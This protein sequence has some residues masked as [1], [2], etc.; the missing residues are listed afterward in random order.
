MDR[1]DF[2]KMV[3]VASGTSI[4]AGCNLDRETEKLIPYLVPPEDG[5]VPGD[6]VYKPTS[7][8][9][10]PAACGMRVTIKDERPAK[11]EG[12]ESHPVGNGALCVRG[13]ASLE[14]L[15]H[16]DRIKQPLMRDGA[17]NFAPAT[18]QQAYAAVVK[19]M[20]VGKENVFLSG[21]TTGT[22]SRLVDEFC[23]R[24]GVTRLPEF[25][26]Y[27]YA[28][29]REA[30]SRLF[31]R[32]VVPA[33]RFEKAD[34]LL[35][36]GADLLDTYGNPVDNTQKISQAR[37]GGGE[38]AHFKW[39]HAE[40]HAT[41]TG[42]RADHRLSVRPGSEATLLAYLLHELRSRRI[43]SD[44]RVDNHIAAVPEAS[45]ENAVAAT[46]LRAEELRQLVEE[47]LAAHSP[48]VVA[49]G[50]STRQAGGLDVARLASLLQ[51]A[52]GMVGETVDY[53]AA[54][55]YSRVGGPRDIESL[56]EMLARGEVG[57]MFVAGSD[58][59]SVLPGRAREGFAGR[60]DQAGL[61]VGVGGFLTETLD[62]CD[63]VFPESHSLESWGDAESVPGVLSSIQA[64]IEPL[65]E[66]RSR[67]DI[68]IQLMAAADRGV[69]AD[70]YQT[71]LFDRWRGDYGAAA[72]EALLTAGYVTYRPRGN[73]AAVS[74]SSRPGRYL[75]PGA[76]VG[77][78]LV[79]APSL[80]F[81]DGRSRVLSLL[82]EIPDPLSSVTWDPW[83]SISPKTAYGLGVK[84][85][86]WVELSNGV[87][88]VELPV[89]IQPGMHDGVFMVE[90]GSVPSPAAWDSST[91]ELEAVTALQS[92]RKIPSRGQLAYLAGT[93]KSETEGHIPL[94][95]IPHHAHD[96][97]LAREDITFF[98]IPDY[99]EYR[100]AMAVDLDKCTGCSA[101]VAAC[102]VEN[103]VPVVGKDEHV[104][105]REMSWLAIQPYYNE[106]ESAELMPVMCQH[107]D[108]AP[109][110][111]VCPVFATYHNDEGLNAQVYN[112]C[113]G[114]RYCANNCPYK[115]R[116]FNWFDNNQKPSPLD[117]M[118]NPDVSRR[119]KGIM[120]KCSFCVQRIRKARD[121]AKDED[122][123]IGS[124]EVV[125]ACA[126]T[127]PGD[128]IAF[129]NIKDENSKVAKW[130]RSE[131][132]HQA[133]EELGTGPAVNY[134]K[135]KGKDLEHG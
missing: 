48:L 95:H 89:I 107:C 120:E 11:L 26:L 25:E 91:G 135:R 6:A 14:R 52:A 67:G 94:Q 71:Y 126:Q 31:G 82:N 54:P 86:D 77:D 75:A 105:G 129:G 60:M 133:L 72:V 21:R 4:L 98:P 47:F 62:R 2:L 103:N 40:P 17:G 131:N 119:G 56:G 18:W 61:A 93:K 45:F 50:V 70:T 59:L 127:C 113:V 116:R 13:Q 79:M 114:T 69:A 12:L 41:L 96:E 63:V 27:S 49:G 73:R 130:A 74:L 23:D 30:N 1:R 34:F 20:A 115:V 121:V 46:G 122:R 110:E 78:V 29:E 108:N 33:Y 80:R 16:P 90:Q 24:L 8:T 43:F 55:D 66:T 128:A 58:P 53:T 88:S 68:L 109:C 65:H 19:A 64:A 51:V 9:E 39:Y 32:P 101:C 38:N 97:S 134:L 3:G 28:A 76:A 37:T 35:S 123:K 117:Q 104:K 44:R 85:R 92:V 125:P 87:W 124:E 36:I 57:V 22:M 5:V 111:P 7:C 81:Y 100:W 118:F 42:V 106:D 112:R 10:C 132:S 102:Y 99:P 15:Y 83:V 84:D